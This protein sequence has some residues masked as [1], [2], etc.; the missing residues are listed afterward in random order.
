MKK[1]GP[2]PVLGTVTASIV[3]LAGTRLDTGFREFYVRK[4]KMRGLAKVEGRSLEILAIAADQP[5]RGHFRKFMQAVKKEYVE[6]VFWDVMSRVLL[7]VLPRYGFWEMKRP[8]PPD[9]KPA[10]C[11]VWLDATGRCVRCGHDTKRSVFKTDLN[12][13]GICTYCREEG[14]THDER[15]SQRN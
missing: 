2:Y 13:N 8:A 3:G 9:G 6:I 12:E 14:V 7:S 5:G 11:F 1:F 10:L 4:F 15:R